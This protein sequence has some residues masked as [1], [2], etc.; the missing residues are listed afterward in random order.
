MHL[1]RRRTGGRV[2]DG[3]SA[4]VWSLAE[5]WPGV[6]SDLDRVQLAMDMPVYRVPWLFGQL[7]M[8]PLYRAMVV[9]RLNVL[10]VA[11]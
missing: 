6:A 8:T 1:P 11:A 3:L 10:V 5:S 9:L 4:V 2:E 7:M